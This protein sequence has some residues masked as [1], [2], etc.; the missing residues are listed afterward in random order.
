[1]RSTLLFIVNLALEIYTFLLLARALLSWARMDP[2]HPVAQF[3]YRVTEPILAPIRRAMPNTGMLDF[4]PL[5]AMILIMILQTLLRGLL[6]TS[7]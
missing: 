2:Y 7:F 3:L 6:L 1:M 5:V 4:S